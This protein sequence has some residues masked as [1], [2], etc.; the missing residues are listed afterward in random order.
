MA[1]NL[2]RLRWVD[3]ISAKRYRHAGPRRSL[4]LVARKE[5][6][7][8]CGEASFGKGQWG[9]RARGRRGDDRSTAYGHFGG[10]GG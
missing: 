9:Y 1:L 8:G 7:D 6:R 4:A 10:G 5:R 2:R 3:M